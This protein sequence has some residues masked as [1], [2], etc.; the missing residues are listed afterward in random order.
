M[1]KDMYKKARLIDIKVTHT[2]DL[3]ESVAY[4]NIE[5]IGNDLKTLYDEDS[6]FRDE[7]NELLS[8]RLSKL[9]DEFNKL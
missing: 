5:I 3:M 6:E 2:K 4:E 7:F 9:T 1:D 8:K